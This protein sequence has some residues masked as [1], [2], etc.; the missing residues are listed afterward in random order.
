M[1]QPE[2]RFFED[3]PDD[4][5]GADRPDTVQKLIPRVSFAVFLTSCF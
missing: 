3:T 2:E 5:F 4:V 1:L